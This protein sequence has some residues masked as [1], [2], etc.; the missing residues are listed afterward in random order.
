MTQNNLQYQILPLSEEFIPQV[1]DIEQACFSDPWSYEG[2]KFELTNPNADFIL[3]VS[4]SGEVYGYV[5]M[6]VVL[7]EGYIANIAVK[8][9][10][11]RFGVASQLMNE[12]LRH[13]EEKAFE[14]ITL[15]VRESN[16]KAIAFYEKYGFK[17]LGMRKNYYS[18]PTENG[19]VMTKF[20]RENT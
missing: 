11:R 15:D 4:N 13:A 14:L 8:S 6:H 17:T 19:L 1:V 5:G 18:K 7:G 2:F 12:V 10:C 20:L 3:A 9:E 16:S